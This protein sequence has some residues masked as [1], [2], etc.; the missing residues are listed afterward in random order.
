MISKD[1]IKVTQHEMSDNSIK[2]IGSLELY[3]RTFIDKEQLKHANIDLILREKTM[4]IKRLHNHIYGDIIEDIC[5]L[6]NEI[7][8]L[9]QN[10]PRG[11]EIEQALT[12]LVNK[13][14][15]EKSS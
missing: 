13:L 15:G 8:P 6:A 5:E 2:L 11:R 10:S 9:T 12:K 4:M 3:E 14:T 7:I 1:D